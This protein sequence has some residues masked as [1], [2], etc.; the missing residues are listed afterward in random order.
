[1]ELRRA[2]GGLILAVITLGL[3]CVTASKPSK[4]KY[5]SLSFNLDTFSL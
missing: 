1:M 4:L 5:L 3:T 2:H